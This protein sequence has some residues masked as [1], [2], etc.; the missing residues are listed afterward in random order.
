MA[1]ENNEKRRE[2]TV[3]VL[4]TFV[5]APVLAVLFVAAY[6]FCVWMIQLIAGP[7]GG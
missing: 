2:L 4:L 5:L 7:P 6:G 1:G 3:F